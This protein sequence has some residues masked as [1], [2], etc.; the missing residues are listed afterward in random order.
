MPVDVGQMFQTY[1]GG[2]KLGKEQ[3]LRDVAKEAV[4]GSPYIDEQ[5]AAF[6]GD[7]VE[8]FEAQPKGLEGEKQYDPEKHVEL[9]KSEGFIKEGMELEEKQAT[10]ATAQADLA[11]KQQKLELDTIKR[12]LDIAR[13]DPESAV[14][15]AQSQGLDAVKVEYKG[16]DN[17]EVTDS[18]GNVTPW[19]YDDVIQARTSAETIYNAEKAAARVAASNKGVDT[20]NKIVARTMNKSIARASLKRQGLTDEQIDK[21]RPELIINNKEQDFLSKYE[22]GNLISAMMQGVS[23]NPKLLELWSADDPGAFFIELATN[24]REELQRALKQPKPKGTSDTKKRKATP[25]QEQELRSD[26]T[27]EGRASFQE[28]FGYLP[29]GL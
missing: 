13:S 21:E 2:A 29:E 17:F 26:N 22:H 3:K 8:G 12:G 7:A 19:N 18:N 5:A 20:P 25:E 15:F 28:T 6:A 14:E 10:I 11:Q 23:Q 16:N 9:L 4:V 27:P 24:Y 1:A